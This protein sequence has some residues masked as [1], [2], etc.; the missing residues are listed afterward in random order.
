MFHLEKKI[1]KIIEEL[2]IF[3]FAV[4]ADEIF[5]NINIKKEDREVVIGIKSNYDVYYSQKVNRLEEYLNK[6]KNEAIEDEYW[7]LA[8]S[9]DPGEASQIILVGMMID[10][11][12]VAIEK[13]VV[14]LMLHKKLE[15]WE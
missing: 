4:G 13:S 14:Y 1:T 2:T 7:E 9:G 6:P 3:F 12:E 15:E 11:A 10:R 5:S 8:G